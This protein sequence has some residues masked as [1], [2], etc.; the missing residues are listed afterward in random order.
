MTSP[1]AGT[2]EGAATAA[3]RAAVARS[4]ALVSVGPAAGWATDHFAKFRRVRKF[5][6]AGFHY[7]IYRSG[8]RFV[9]LVKSSDLGAV[10]VAAHV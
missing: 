8:Y 2:A 1:G 7:G 6:Y 4:P 9:R 5:L 3:A 10:I